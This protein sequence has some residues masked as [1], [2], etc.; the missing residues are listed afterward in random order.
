M[1]AT[2]SES[3]TEFTHLLDP[4]LAKKMYIVYYCSVMY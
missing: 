2:I 4:K 3:D 1:S